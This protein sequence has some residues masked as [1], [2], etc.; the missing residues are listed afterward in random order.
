MLTVRKRV[1]VI[2][3]KQYP[4]PAPGLPLTKA[5]KLLQQEHPELTN[6]EYSSK[7]EGDKDVYTFGIKTGTYA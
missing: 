4:D 6:S 7:V 5:I 2:G 1:F 3:G